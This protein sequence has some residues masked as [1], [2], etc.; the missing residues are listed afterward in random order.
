MEI[1]RWFVRPNFNVLSGSASFACVFVCNG[2]KLNRGFG[3]PKMDSDW[4][5]QLPA[6]M[7]AY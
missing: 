5:I 6:C 2:G 3:I 4:D 7:M 1:L